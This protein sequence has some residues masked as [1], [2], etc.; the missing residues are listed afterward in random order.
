MLIAVIFGIGQC[1]Q[2][3]DKTN[4]S[5]STAA[6]SNETPTSP[7]PSSGS[8]PDD[9]LELVEMEYGQEAA[10]VA[11][12]GMMD[13]GAASAGPPP[14]D[15]Q[16]IKAR[17]LVLTLRN[18][19]DNPLVLTGLK[20]VVHEVFQVPTC[21]TA[22]GGGV[23]PTLNY[24]FRFPVPPAGEWSATE[25]Q[26][27]AVKPR[28]VDALSVTIGPAESGDPVYV[29]RYSVYA[30]VKQG[31]EILWG[32]GVGTDGFEVSADDYRAYTRYGTP[33]NASPAEIRACAREVVEK[34]RGYSGQSVQPTFAVQPEI[35]NL[36]EA[37][38]ELA[39][40]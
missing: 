27:F 13:L 16:P 11:V 23:S 22:V 17:P 35:E 9:L 26:N 30:V 34:V 25:P 15:A 6:A 28:S 38:E 3:T 2:A 24:D 7:P 32:G 33:T 10:Q 5:Q 40:E 19:G 21:A 18:T 31:R 4:G 1:G 14:P 20:L 39:T 36:I 29:W 37:Y 8:P 12:T